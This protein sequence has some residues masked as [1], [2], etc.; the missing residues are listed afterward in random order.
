[1]K[2]YNGIEVVNRIEDEKPIDNSPFFV[3]LA[4]NQKRL[5]F[6]SGRYSTFLIDKMESMEKLIGLE[7]FVKYQGE[8]IFIVGVKQ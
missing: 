3:S 7:V 4:K 2:T 8:C 5:Y 1:M 6:N